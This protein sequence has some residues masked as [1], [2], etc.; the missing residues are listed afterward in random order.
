MKFG[1][2]CHN[3]KKSTAL[4][5]NHRSGVFLVLIKTILD[6][7]FYFKCIL[8]LAD[9]FRTVFKINNCDNISVYLPAFS[10]FLY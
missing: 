1:A 4:N 8:S 3:V 9:L 7:V 2:R 5:L 10:F 6:L